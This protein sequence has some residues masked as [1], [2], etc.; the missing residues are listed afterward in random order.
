MLKQVF[1]AHFEPVLTEFSPFHHMY[2]P[3]CPPPIDTPL[4]NSSWLHHAALR[5]M[6]RVKLGAY[7]GHK[8]LNSIKT[9]SK[10]AHFT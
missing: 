2:A 10:W 9:S 7:I 1:L 8:E 6:R 5:Y 3:R 4:P